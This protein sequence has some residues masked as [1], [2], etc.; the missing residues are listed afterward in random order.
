MD[1]RGAPS[2]PPEE[3]PRRVQEGYFELL[4]GEPFL[5][6]VWGCMLFSGG[7]RSG[8]HRPNNSG[9]QGWPWHQPRAESRELKLWDPLVT[10]HAEI[11]S[12]GSGVG[13]LFAIYNIP[14]PKNLVVRM[15]SPLGQLLLLSP[16]L[17]LLPENFG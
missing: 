11:P 17:P 16:S 8:G 14:K 12:A 7:G 6:D 2:K 15:T 3:L 10:T 5:K 9:S 13:G 1:D 4:S